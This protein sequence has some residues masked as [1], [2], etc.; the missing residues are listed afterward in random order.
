MGIWSRIG[1]AF[2]FRGS[3]SEPG[4]GTAT[5]VSS[6]GMPVPYLRRGV[7]ELFR[8]YSLSPYFRMVNARLAHERATA[9]RK[10]RTMFDG[11]D[12]D[13]ARV[14]I[15]RDD[16]RYEV[17]R[18]LRRPVVMASGQRMTFYQREKICALWYGLAGEAYKAKLRGPAGNVIGLVPIS[19]LWVMQTPTKAEPHYL[20]QA[21][22]EVEPRKI[23]ASEMIPY[24]DTGA[25]N[26]YGRGI[27][28]GMSLA[29]EID[30]DD[31]IARMSRAIIANQGT[32]QGM[33]VLEGA[34]KDDVDRART[35][36]REKFGGPDKAGQ[37]EFARGKANFVSFQQNRIFSE[38]IEARKSIRDMFCHVNGISPEVF[39]IL[40]GSTRD[41]NWVAYQSFA[42]SSLVPWLEMAVDTEQAY[43]V[44][45]FASNPEE[46][47]LGYTSPLP[48]DR[49]LQVRVMAT[50]PGAFKG[51]DARKVGGFAPD[52]DLDDLP[53][54]S[55]AQ[56]ATPTQLPG[57][58]GPA[59]ALLLA[60][61]P[62]FV[63]ALA[64]NPTFTRAISKRIES[65]LDDTPTAVVG[66]D[67]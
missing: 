1:N 54:G 19:P 32:P 41:S 51:R 24:V 27:G 67:S 23:P 58:N 18:I 2:R 6:F 21:S 7:S 9:L 37:I 33:L 50:A 16:P 60:R 30:T 35:K 64:A 28:A 36:W 55:D 48:D 31:G 66:S 20:V 14:Q 52:P 56:R 13:P 44:P 26:P 43:L 8:S 10:C 17:M 49:D 61:E 12:D 39:G 3:S 47:C 65:P 29:Q 5:V 34:D 45:D 63:R 4:G 40:D 53:L 38:S 22:P 57:T 25:E 46:A 42:Q 15:G 62:E 59:N 11:P